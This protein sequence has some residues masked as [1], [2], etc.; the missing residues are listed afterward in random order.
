ML[1]MSHRP[2]MDLETQELRQLGAAN[3]SSP[4][5]QDMTG[6]GQGGAGGKLP[7]T[8]STSVLRIK[9][10]SAFWDKLWVNSNPSASKGASFKQ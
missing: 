6:G 10:R 4:N 2:S 8:L 7:R 3:N 9:A 1:S 5:L